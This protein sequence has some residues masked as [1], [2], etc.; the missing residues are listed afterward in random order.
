MYRGPTTVEVTL[1][2][3]G[4]ANKAPAKSAHNQC[5]DLFVTQSIPG[6]VCS[7]FPTCVFWQLFFRRRGI[8]S[9]TFFLKCFINNTSFGAQII[10]RGGSE[11]PQTAKAD[12]GTFIGGGICSFE[13]LCPSFC[14]FL[15]DS[16]RR[17]YLD[18]VP[19]LLFSQPM[20]F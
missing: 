2:F 7:S 11:E 5:S 17:N 12:R 9:A 14:P 4:S 10:L 8:R 15:E 20:C 6:Y 3:R 1:D 19:A 18:A 13:E 16:V